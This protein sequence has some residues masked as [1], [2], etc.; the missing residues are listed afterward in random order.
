MRIGKNPEKNKQEKILYKQHRIIVPVYIPISND[1][2]F[3]NL[4]EVFKM[5]INSIIKT[6]D[7]SQTVITIINNNCKE[8]VTS[9]IDDLLIKKVI[10]KHVKLSKNYGKVQTILSEARASYEDII[11]IVDADA[12]FFNN[13]ESEVFKIFKVFE[14]VGVV[15]PLPAPH[16]VYYN[17]CSSFYFNFFNINSRKIVKDESFKLFEEGTDNKAIFGKY[18]KKQ[19]YIEKRGIKVCLGAGHF[20][21]TYRG[22]ILR[23]IPFCKPEFVFKN[24]YEDQV[25]DSQIDKLGYYRVSLT[26]A[27]VYHL[28]NTIPKW[29]IDYNF[30]SKK[31]TSI[32]LEPYIKSKTP[33]ILGKVMIKIFKLFNTKD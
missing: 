24:G 22:D 20:A 26:D 30:K 17:N 33:Y 12:L 13:W 2:Y 23:T 11:T 14:K 28:G 7:T 1:G 3:E 27:F 15:S 31:G 25:L 4:F 10:D 5:S 19:F 32:E 21:A 6:I 18:K 8:E 16:L 9:Y 29:T